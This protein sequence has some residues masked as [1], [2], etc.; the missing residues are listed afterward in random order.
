MTRTGASRT[1][2]MPVKSLHDYRFWPPVAHVDN[3]FG[4]R[5]PVCSG[6]GME[7]YQ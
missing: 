1:G 4:D 7:N 5:N 6:V 2:A 3:A